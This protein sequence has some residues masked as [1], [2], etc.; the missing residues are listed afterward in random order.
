VKQVI[1]INGSLKLPKGKLAAQVAH[2]A[3]A[4]FVAAPSKNKK[5]WLDAGMPKIVLSASGEQELLETYQ[6][7]LN[8]NLPSQLIKDA[9]RTVIAAGTITCVG[10]GPALG[11]KIDQITGQLK[12]VG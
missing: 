5:A 4:S 2:A 12:L 7:A 10:V 6:K 8:A 1:I 11:E 3:V 9:G